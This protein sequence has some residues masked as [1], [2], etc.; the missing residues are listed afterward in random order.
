MVGVSVATS[1]GVAVA[2]GLLVAV[3]VG[4][5]VS[6]WVGT[7]VVVPVAVAVGVFVGWLVGVGVSVGPPN[8][9]TGPGNP[10][11]N[12]IRGSSSSRSK[13]FVSDVL[14]SVAIVT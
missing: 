10:E 6:V 7:A 1:V 9:K 12:G 3:A 11:G 8:T 13:S 4:V 2:P 5:G 14:G